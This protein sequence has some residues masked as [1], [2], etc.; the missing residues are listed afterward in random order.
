MTDETNTEL[1]GT[2]VPEDDMD[3]TTTQAETPESGV[4][5]PQGETGG[6]QAAEENPFSLDEPEGD[7]EAKA[8]GETG[9]E[10]E[11]AFA[12]EGLEGIDITDEMK[13][14][15]ES[16]AKE[17]GL[18]GGK[19]GKYISK[20][21][22]AELNEKAAQLDAQEVEL[23]K[24][25][26]A[27]FNENVKTARAFCRQLAGRAGVDMKVMQVFASPAGFKLMYALSQ[28]V[29]E[30]GVVTGNP[31]NQGTNEAEAHR[32][33]TDPTHPLYSA[34]YNPDDARYEE[35]NRIYNRLVGLE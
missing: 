11:E 21:I 16:L 25:W 35:A 20:V 15:Y 10:E 1:V 18:P 19:A 7:G 23:R 28:A 33:I 14:R 5:E 24:E 9:G 22:E 8:E 32:M 12:L 6:E 34:F 30:P 26:G 4:E 13:G 31:S 2:V 27:K 3:M 17:V 29:G